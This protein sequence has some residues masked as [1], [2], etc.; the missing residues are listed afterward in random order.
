MDVSA[1]AST[2]RGSIRAVPSKSMGHR[3]LI[4]AALSGGGTVSN[5]FFSADIQATVDALSAMGF[6]LRQTES[7]VTAAGFIP[8]VRPAIDCNESGSTLRF[9]LPV[10]AALG[11]SAVF[12][13]RGRLPSRPIG[14]L[15]KELSRHGVSCS[16]GTLP[17]TL[18]GRLQPGRYCLPGNV[19]SQY[20][21]GL[22]FA[23][24]LLSGDSVIEITTPLE[25]KPYL[26]LTIQALSE[27][28]IHIEETP[29]G[30]AVPGGQR[31]LP[32]DCAVEGDYSNAAF[33][34]CGGALTGRV[35]TEGLAA[36]SLQGDKNIFPLLSRMG[37]YVRR[38]G[39]AVFVC[40]RKMYGITIDA[41]QIPD[42]VPILAVTAALCEGRTV[43]NN[44]GRL[45]LKESDRLA[46]VSDCLRRLGGK[47]E[48][49]PDSLAI[50]G[51]PS[52]AGGEVDG[53]NDHRIVM[54]M[55]VAALRCKRPVTIRGAQAVEKSYGSFWSDY[56]SLGGNCHVIHH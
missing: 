2:L 6:L 16:G 37:A 54:A 56:Q 53:Y 19:S 50:T 31:Y 36:R 10:A 28:G 44:A 22:L 35:L 20:I 39:E 26:D 48:E 52:L 7:T 32:R 34:A 46:A 43:I 21:S 51:Q 33:F 18:S 1:S 29:H 40:A 8:P 23:L 38:E 41:S 55:A 25:S 15:T 45:R 12:T 42:L 3:S 13:G 24:P 30:Y 47:V 11:I 17:L 5:L 49:G 4:C 27:Y 9:L 14:V